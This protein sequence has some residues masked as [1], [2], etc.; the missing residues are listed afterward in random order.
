MAEHEIVHIAIA[1][2]D[3]LGA[4]LIEKVAA[5]VNKD[6]YDTRLLLRGNIPRIITQCQSIP[7]AES[8]VQSLRDLGLVAIICEDSELRKP[9]QSFVARTMQFGEGEVLIWEKDGQTRRVGP[10]DVFLMLKGSMPTY[11]EAESTTTRMKFSLTATLLTGG[12]PIWRRVREKT[13]GVSVQDKCFA[14]LYSRGSSE[15]SVDIIQDYMDYSFL[16]EK[17]NYSSLANFGTV[18][19]GLREIFPQAIFDERL[20][21]P[22][23]EH[24]P[25]A[26]AL[27]ELEV[28][29]KLIYLCHLAAS[30]L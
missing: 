12:I 11:T 13:R 10:D 27:S 17:M 18:I 3:T 26:T 24:M 15:P 20:M 8:I 4:G 5:I 22:F 28:N 25:P 23:D 1:P 7:T 6:L 16:G 30:G 2:P 14:R 29:C 9:S 19:A 21:R